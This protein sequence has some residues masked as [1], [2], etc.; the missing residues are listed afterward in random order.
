MAVIEFQVSIN[1]F[2]EGYI[3]HI[4]YDFSTLVSLNPVILKQWK[5][6]V[7]IKIT[8]QYIRAEY[9]PAP[10]EKLYLDLLEH[11]L[12]VLQRKI[13]DTASRLAERYNCS[14]P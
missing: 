9:L 3:R 13:R 6:I 7:L 5:G 4:I 11:E 8:P 2:P 12:S 10:G 14:I 1:S